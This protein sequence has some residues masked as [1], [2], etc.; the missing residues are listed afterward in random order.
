VWR[1]PASSLRFFVRSN[2]IVRPQRMLST[3]IPKRFGIGCACR[4]A[5]RAHSQICQTRQQNIDFRK[6]GLTTIFPN[7][8]CPNIRNR[9]VS[10]RWGVG[11]SGQVWGGR[12]IIFTVL[13]R[14]EL[15]WN[16]PPVLCSCWG[17]RPSRRPH[18]EVIGRRRA[19][20]QSPDDAMKP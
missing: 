17:D 19:G 1:C 10:V 5:P 15:V 20:S 16:A 8:T 18:S 13:F 2:G 3:K 4:F 12:T 7:V 6:I 9:I 14:H 11:H